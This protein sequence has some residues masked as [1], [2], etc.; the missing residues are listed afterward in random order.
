V[1]KAFPAHGARPSARPEAFPKHEP[2]QSALDRVVPSLPARRSCSCSLSSSGAGSG[3][4][5]W[6]WTS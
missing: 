5:G 1:A 6:T 2:S 3:E 4:G